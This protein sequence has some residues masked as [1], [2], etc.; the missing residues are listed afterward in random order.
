MDEIQP[1]RVKI[2]LGVM[3]TKE[4]LYISQNSG[5]P[6]DVFVSF[7]RFSKQRGVYSIFR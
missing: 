7:S 3:V 1:L 6:P 5:A 4:W 2:D